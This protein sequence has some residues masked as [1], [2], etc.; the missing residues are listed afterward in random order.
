MLAQR[1]VDRLVAGTKIRRRA[2][3]RVVIR[4]NV[5]IFKLIVRGIKDCLESVDSEVSISFGS[6]A[7]HRDL[8]AQTI[9]DTT[10][11]FKSQLTQFV[12]FSKLAV[13]KI[14]LP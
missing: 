5:S 9:E 2:S 11:I 8:F 7:R 1:V 13:C 10:H 4:F 6:V 12:I 14:M 3:S